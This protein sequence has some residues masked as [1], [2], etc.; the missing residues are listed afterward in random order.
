MVSPDSLL[1]TKWQRQVAR[2]FAAFVIFSLLQSITGFAQQAAKPKPRHEDWES[3]IKAFEMSDKTNPPPKNAILFIGSSSMRIWTNVADYFQ[4]QTIINRGFGG[5]QI[6]DSVR[7]VER[8]VLPYQPKAVVFYAGDNDMSYGK[9]PAQIATDFKRFVTKVHWA[10]PDTK[11]FFISIKPSPSR[12]KYHEKAVE[13]NN[14]IK[15]F[16][17]KEKELTFIDVYQSMLGDD[18][19]PRAE[20]FQKDGLHLN[21]KGYD[22]WAKIIRPY[23]EGL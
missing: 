9:T 23:L 8:I 21:P 19:L 10:L 22:L 3:A 15:D 5:S 16:S 2:S 13:A 6:S 20:L 11:I 1:A 4:G 14:L 12:W 18:G 17:K 7:Y